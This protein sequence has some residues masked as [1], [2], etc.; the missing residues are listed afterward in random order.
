MANNGVSGEAHRR[1]SCNA[2]K[3]EEK[4]N[5]AVHSASCNKNT[6]NRATNIHEHMRSSRR[7]QTLTDN[8][9]DDPNTTK[10]R[11][12][13]A[14]QRYAI[15]MAIRWRADNGPTLNSGLVAF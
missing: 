6:K 9:L 3:P 13:S 10:S 2:D 5:K 14:C 4:A 7:G 11:P 1:Q 12:S 8:V 15:K